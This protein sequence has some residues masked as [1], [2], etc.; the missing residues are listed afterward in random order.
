MITIIFRRKHLKR[1]DLLWLREREMP[2]KKLRESHGQRISPSFIFILVVVNK[3]DE[4]ENH[5]TAKLYFYIAHVLSHSKGYLARCHT[6]VSLSQG[7]RIVADVF[8]N[9]FPDS[10]PFFF[11]IFFFKVFQLPT[12]ELQRPRLIK[13]HFL[14]SFLVLSPELSPG[15]LN[16]AD[17][18]S[19]W[20]NL[21]LFISCWIDTHTSF[22]LFCFCNSSSSFTDYGVN[23][24]GTPVVSHAQLLG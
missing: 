4:G 12:N 19:P 1:K 18:P 9:K 6:N 14:N 13:K 20:K 2:L 21:K 16:V 10:L 7:A 5:T 8:F 3:G 24:R 22:S 23:L 17:G 15:I 11:V